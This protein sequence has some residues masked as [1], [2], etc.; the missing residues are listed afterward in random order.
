MSR[1]EWEA[2]MDKD[3]VFCDYCKRGL[4]PYVLKNPRIHAHGGCNSF[5]Q[6]SFV[7]GKCCGE[8][9]ELNQKFSDEASSAP[10]RV[11]REEE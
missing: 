1:E 3:R 2:Y 4:G 9:Y 10:Q 8:Q 6:P 7:V 5:G 11:Q